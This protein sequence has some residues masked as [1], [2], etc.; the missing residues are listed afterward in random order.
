MADRSY[1]VGPLY[2]LVT[3]KSKPEVGERDD[4]SHSPSPSPSRLQW[5]PPHRLLPIPRRSLGTP[6]AAPLLPLLL[7]LPVAPQG[8]LILF[9]LI[10]ARSSFLEALSIDS[11]RFFEAI[12]FFLHAVF[13]SLRRFCCLSPCYLWF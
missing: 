11:C 5:R 8:P 12:R 1:R 3:P 2:F 9:P 7:L 4:G 10:R 13:D 6:R